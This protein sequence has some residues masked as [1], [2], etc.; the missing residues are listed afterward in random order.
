[1]IV[2]AAVFRFPDML[3]I[4]LRHVSGSRASEV[5][6]IPVGAHRELI[7][8]RAASAAVRFDGQG[9]PMVGRQHARILCRDDPAEPFLLTDLASRNGTFLNGRRL[10][11]PVPV[12]D[13]DRMQLGAGGPVL[14]FAV[15]QYPAAFDAL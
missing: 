10:E 1:M 11:A 5:D 2:R 4:I 12:R 14:V 13:G 3:R 6:V 9:D 8:G 7:L 15:E